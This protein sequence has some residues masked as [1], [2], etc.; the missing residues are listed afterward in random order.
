M[1]TA[2]KI[3]PY[4]GPLCSEPERTDRTCSWDSVLRMNRK[5]KGLKAKYSRISCCAI[6]I[7]GQR[8]YICFSFLFS[9]IGCVC[10][11]VRVCLVTIIASK[12]KNNYMY[13][14]IYTHTHMYTHIQ[15]GTK[16]GLKSCEY[17]NTEFII[18]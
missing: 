13:T 4:K 17:K 15:G 1:W 8:C 16:I 10:M 5:S 18:Y 6:F 3:P 7:G 12:G 2:G 11:C 14:H 9:Q